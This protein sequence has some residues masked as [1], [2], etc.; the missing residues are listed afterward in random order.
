VLLTEA[1]APVAPPIEIVPGNPPVLDVFLLVL[2]TGLALEELWDTAFTEVREDG[3]WEQ[4]F[5]AQATLFET[6]DTEFWAEDRTVLAIEEIKVCGINE[7]GMKV[8]KD[9]T[10]KVGDG[11][12]EQS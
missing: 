1:R 6:C 7:V 9:V 4:S 5:P 10:F 8:A 12:R 11:E 3:S 2:F